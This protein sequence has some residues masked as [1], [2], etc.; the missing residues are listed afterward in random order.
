M[1]F[2]P[3]CLSPPH[4]CVF[5]SSSERLQNG[6][7]RSIRYM[8][9]C[10]ARGGKDKVR[11]G[12][13]RLI[14]RK[15]SAPPPIQVTLHGPWPLRNQTSCSS[16]CRSWWRRGTCCTRYISDE[17]VID[18]RC[19]PLW[20]SLRTA[21]LRKD[22]WRRRASVTS[23]LC[24]SFPVRARGRSWRAWGTCGSPSTSTSPAAA[25]KPT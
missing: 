2:A 6:S 16:C 20:P 12:A 9:H 14:E 7:T 5:V 25:G 24:G 4:P 17:R 23:T 15:M 22:G 19:P 11:R 3:L 13:A 21:F 8:I 10:L 18:H 1:I